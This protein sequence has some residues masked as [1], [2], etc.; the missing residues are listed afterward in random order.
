ME[1]RKG[2][3]IAIGSSF[4]NKIEVCIRNNSDSEQNFTVQLRK[5]EHIWDYSVDKGEVLSEAELSIAPGTHWVQWPVNLKNAPVGE[6]VRLDILPN[7]ALEWLCAGK[8]ESGHMAMY[9]ISA[10]KMRRFGNGQTL[11]FRIEPAQPCFSPQNVISGVT[12]PHK[13][14]NLWKSDPNLPLSQFLQLSWEKSKVIKGIELTFPGHLL[15]EYHAYDPFYRD[16]QCPKDYEVLALK[17]NKWEKVLEVTENYQRQV[18]HSF[19][20]I[21]TTQL[22]IQVNATNGDPSAQIYEIR[23]Y[24]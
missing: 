12:R 24:E 11:S 19:E 1:C 9:Q 8:I 18:K 14:T 7:A 16:P 21:E 20:G 13:F 6:F 22:R 2:Q 17:D 3:L 4:I 23:C 5:S 10:E 15:R